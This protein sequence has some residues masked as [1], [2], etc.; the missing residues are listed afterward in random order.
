MVTLSSFVITP[1]GP[2][3]EVITE[4]ASSNPDVDA[5]IHI[6]SRGSPTFLSVDTSEMLE[7]RSVEDTNLIT[8]SFV[9]HDLVKFSWIIDKYIP[10]MDMKLI[11]ATCHQP[12]FMSWVYK[13]LYVQIKPHFLT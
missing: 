8:T 10:L 3:Q 2:V 12:H 13:T 9:L 5:T 11:S 7:K 1:L 4:S 6:T